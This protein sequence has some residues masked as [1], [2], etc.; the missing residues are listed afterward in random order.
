MNNVPAFFRSFIIYA[1]CVV[2]AIWLGF[3]LAGP[4]TYSSL[5]IY[6]FLAAVL[7]FPL[8][9]RW[10]FPL[11]L[12]SWNMAAFV[13]FLPG[14]PSL[15]LTMIA[16]SLGISVFH[17]MLSRESRFIQVPQLVLPLLCLTV[18]I[19]V[20]AKLTGLGLRTFGSDVYGGK[21][22]VYLLGAILGYFALSAHRIPPERKN[23]YIALFFLGGIS[24]FIGDLLLF[25]PHSLYFIYW[26]FQPNEYFFTTG[27]LGEEAARF[28]GA[29]TTS[30]AVLSYMLARYGIRGIFLSGKPLRWITL[31]LISIYGLLGGF[32]GFV[33]LFALVFALQFF[34]EG[35]HRTKLLPVL[36]FAGT[37]TAVALV[38]L[39]P[40]LPH[41][42]QRALSFLP[43][44]VDPMDRQDAQGSLD[45]RIQMWKGLLPQVPQYLLL[46]KGYAIAPSDYEFAMGPDIS[47]HSVFAENQGLA[48]AGDYHSG[49]LSVILPFGIWGGIAFV[50]FLVAAIRVLHAN[51][52]YGDP[53]LRM[54]NT[55]LLAAFVARVIFFFL[56]VGALSS[57][58]LTFCGLI[59]LSVSLNGGVCRP[60]GTV[61]PRP[62]TNS[63]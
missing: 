19:V 17:R 2:L 8:L 59:G 37:L 50:W 6:G 36:L 51:Y 34:L 57:D 11:L 14:R 24:A 25:M 3:L 41:T 21:K 31:V 56:M 33:L 29:W 39:A 15:C 32:R 48:L 28:G 45:W 10:H 18:V 5:A 60:S 4:L 22:Y 61:P 35:L 38:P 62:Q 47:T 52:R 30:F 54:I 63:R 16:L 13:F 27:G 44:K 12:L 9:L 26:F 42:F 58:M 40:H 53:S 1:V 43:L 20:T 55:F 46:G 7:I 49:P 23:L